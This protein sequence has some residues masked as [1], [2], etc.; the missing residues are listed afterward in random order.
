LQEQLRSLYQA[1]SYDVN[2]E[3]ADEVLAYD[4]SIILERTKGEIAARCDKVE[5]NFLAINLAN[6]VATG[7][8]S[9][10]E[11]RQ[12]YAQSMMK[13]MKQGEMNEYMKEF[14]FGVL[15]TNVGDS[16]EPFG[17]VGT[18]GKKPEGQ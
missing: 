6:D 15:R 4:G 9:V 11:A 16:D 13:M 12:F 3:N 7:K 14:T 2:P 8:K 18:S 5:A 17:P 1:V 10:E